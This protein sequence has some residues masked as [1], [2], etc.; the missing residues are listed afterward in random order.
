LKK[1]LEKAHMESTTIETK[2]ETDEIT[3][4]EL[5]L[6]LGRWYSYLRSKW[7]IILVMGIIGG[8][9]GFTFSLLSKPTFTASTTF[10]LEDSE[11]SGG[12]GSYAGLASMVGIDL[13]GSGGGIFQG[14]NILELYKSRAMIEKTLLSE[15]AYKGK[16]VLLIDVYIDF[17]E[18][19]SKWIKK[20][21]LKNIQ[22]KPATHKNLEMPVSD[23][24]RLQDSV[25]G[26]IV[27]DI[28][29][30]YLTVAKPDKKINIINAQ[31]KAKDETFAKMFDEQIV[32]NVNDFYVQTKTKKSTD[33]L[34]IMQH[35]TDS[36]RSV[37]NGAIYTAAVVTDA[38]PNLNITRQIQR[39][40]PLQRSQFNVETNKA[41]LA[42]LVKNL[43]LSKISLLK[44]TPLIQVIDRPVYPLERQRLGKGKGIIIGGILMGFLTVV[45]LLVKKIFKSIM[46]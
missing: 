32:K 24:T 15:V 7:L 17:N 38:T 1:Q 40:A 36:V 34:A 43:E 31:V 18:L 12:M 2:K 28:N 25:I 19:R 41:V 11:K 42:E 26:M 30:N 14:D 22:F 10:V 39:T 16:K 8:I 46:A 37:M 13:T 29:K 5:L 20:P 35:K 27:N 9:L 33:N 23:Q 6:R 21:E 44:E 45:V 3:L 4:K